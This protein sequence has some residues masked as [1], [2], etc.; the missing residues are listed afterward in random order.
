MCVCVRA[1]GV[2]ALSS[3]CVRWSVM[4]AISIVQS[5]QFVHGF[6]SPFNI[7]I[8]GIQYIYQNS[9]E[10]QSSSIRCC[11]T[12]NNT[13]CFNSTHL[14]FV[15]RVKDSFLLLFF[16]AGTYSGYNICKLIVEFEKQCQ[17]KILKS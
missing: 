9:L 12:S 10:G 16:P 17:H 4:I 8:R 2:C 11:G 1:C 15:C 7:V 3:V 13:A 5:I 14:I 6:N